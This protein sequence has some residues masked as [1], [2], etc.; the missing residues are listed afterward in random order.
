MQDES[1]ID[2]RIFARIPIGLSIR[3]L[4]SNMDSECRGQT[5]DVSANGVSFTSEESFSPQTAL[6][7]WLDLPENQGPFYTRGKVVWS[8]NSSDASRRRIGVHL[9]KA[10]LM[11]LAPILWRENGS[12]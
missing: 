10:E 8:S 4:G 11:G 5:I 6:E 1:F 9:E 3:F 2:R 12:K 7:M